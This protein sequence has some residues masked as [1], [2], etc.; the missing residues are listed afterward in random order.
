V[1]EYIPSILGDGEIWIENL[2]GMEL[3]RHV[4]ILF[5]HFLGVREIQDRNQAFGIGKRHFFS[6][7][8]FR[9]VVTGYS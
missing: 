1:F 7:T 9:K 3:G 6:F 4:C 8:N 2:D 5:E